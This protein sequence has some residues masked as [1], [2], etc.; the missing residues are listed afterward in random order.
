MF[1]D[2]VTGQQRHAP[3]DGA[4][5]QV[6]DQLAADRGRCHDV[7][8]GDDPLDLAADVGGVPGRPPRPQA[9]EH[10]VGH[11]VPVDPPDRDGAVLHPDSWA[12]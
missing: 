4:L 2:V 5:G 7:D 9:R 8:G 6:L 3:A 1:G 11:R 10:Q 12:E